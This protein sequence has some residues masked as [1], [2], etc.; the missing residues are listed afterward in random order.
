MALT[1]VYISPSGAGDNS[2]SSVANALPA[3]SSGDWST[4]IK[5]LTRADRRFIFLEG[6][7]N[8]SSELVFTSSDPTIAD[9]N[10]WVG[11]KSDG[12]LL[13]PQFDETGMHL[14]TDNYPKII[15]SANSNLIDTSATEVFKC[16]YFENTN[17]SRNGYLI[18][19]VFNEAKNISFIG[20]YG[21]ITPNGSNSIIF[22]V[23][24]GTAL[25]CEA[26]MNGTN[27]GKIIH[28]GGT[29][30]SAVINCRVYGGGKSGSSDGRGIE[31]GTLNDS[32][33]ETLIYNVHGPAIYDGT[34]NDR[35]S[36]MINC[37]VISVGGDGHNTS[38]GVDDQRGTSIHGNIFF[39]VD[40][41]GVVAKTN[42]DDIVIASFNAFGDIGGSNF[43]NLDS[44]ESMATIGNKTVS[45]SDFVDFANQ[46]FRI[47]RSSPLYK[48]IGGTRN[49]GAI[50]NQDFE[51]VGA[52]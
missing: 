7:Y 36:N 29:N 2:G 27:Y 8:V 26:V 39:D 4:N 32:V 35:N 5:G 23:W 51:F 11:A 30:Q 16:I 6:T 43:V 52:G 40:G 12:T 44:Y 45:E 31:L 14:V 13:E 41:D 20:C 46:D 19:N 22:Q 48:G 10:I 50:Q 37:T 25:M 34:S 21:K 38:V 15:N 42:D 18:N 9:P 28:A 24:G 47:R 33:I 49:F 17:S 3:V 1:D